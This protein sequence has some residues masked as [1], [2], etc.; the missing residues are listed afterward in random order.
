MKVEPYIR[1]GKWLFSGSTSFSLHKPRR[2]RLHDC[3]ESHRM[4]VRRRRRIKNTCINILI[5]VKDRGR[6]DTYKKCRHK[7][8]EVA[9][10]NATKQAEPQTRKDN[11]IYTHCMKHTSGTRQEQC[12]DTGNRLIPSRIQ[13]EKPQINSNNSVTKS[14]NQ[15]RKKMEIEKRKTRRKQ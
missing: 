2:S 4:R 13:K 12:L 6:S 14:P 3:P 11:M 9:Q 8:Y 7:T 1:P 10:K 5:E 15:K